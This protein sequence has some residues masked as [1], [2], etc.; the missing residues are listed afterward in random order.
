MDE[1]I[2]SGLT[3]V[4]SFLEAVKGLPRMEKEMNRARKKVESK[5]ELLISKMEISLAL[6]QELQKELK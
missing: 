1:G 3:G 4:L 6:S 5:L 2:S